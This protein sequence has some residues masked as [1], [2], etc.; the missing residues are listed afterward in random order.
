MRIKRIEF[1]GQLRWVWKD[2]EYQNPVSE[3]PFIC[4]TSGGARAMRNYRELRQA[5]STVARNGDLATPENYQWRKDIL[6]WLRDPYKSG[7]KQTPFICWVTA[8]EYRAMGKA[9]RNWQEKP[10]PI[11]SK[12]IRYMRDGIQAYWRGEIDGRWGWKRS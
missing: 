8:E 2:D 6:A 1:E 12:L 7:P 10:T 5:L 9:L 11:Y 3:R 4:S